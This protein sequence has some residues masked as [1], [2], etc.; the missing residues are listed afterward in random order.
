VTIHFGN[1][2]LNSTLYVPFATYNTAGASVT[3]TGLAVT[4]I[5]IYKDGSVTQR[6]SDNGYA[7]LDTDGIDFDGITGLHGFSIDTSDNSTASFYA[8]GS[9]YWVVVSTVT[10]DSQTVTHLACTFRLGPPEANT[11][12]IAGA[13]VST[14]TA[15]IGVNVI[16]AAGTAWGSGAIT[17]ASIAPDAIGASELAAD[18]A[19]EI[20]TAVWATAARSLTVLDEDTTTLDLD[21]TI[22]AAVG[23]ATANLDTQLDAL[24]TAAEI[25]AEVVDALAT[26]TYAEPGQA[27]PPATAS[28]SAKVGYL[29]KLERNKKDQTDSLFQLYGDDGSTVHQKAS[30][31]SDG[32]TLTRGELETGP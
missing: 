7:L 31:S 3:L 17:A 5:E 19:T 28:L 32:T 22:R 27:N 24:P 8:A 13:A 1:I 14:S 21:A 4:D 10:I 16:Q 18:A 15:Q 29:Y 9:Q 20:G 25:N 11:T 23:L 26:D 30:V 12:Q 2:P 6:A